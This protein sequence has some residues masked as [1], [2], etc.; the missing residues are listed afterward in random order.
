MALIPPTEASSPFQ[1]RLS[2]NILLCPANIIVPFR[3]A[4]PC[5]K[6]D[7]S[8]S[9][10]PPPCLFSKAKVLL[11]CIPPGGD[12]SQ[13]LTLCHPCLLQGSRMDEQR[14]SFPPPL[15]VCP[16]FPPL[17]RYTRWALGRRGQPQATRPFLSAAP[18]LLGN[19]A[20]Q[21][22]MGG[23]FCSGYPL[24]GQLSFPLGF[25]GLQP[26]LLPSSARLAETPLCPS[27]AQLWEVPPARKCSNVCK[28]LCGAVT[29]CPREICLASDISK[30]W[31]WG[32]IA[33]RVRA[34]AQ[35]PGLVPP[36]AT[37]SG[38]AA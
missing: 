16:S 32:C 34:T 11:A 9:S 25:Q 31:G 5:A 20:L 10:S 22:G 17:L 18:H 2:V 28:P 27:P 8:S 36:L 30:E 38:R 19:G 37:S 29:R 33:F 12:H 1:S 4:C 7:V 26:V 6:Q 24:I 14:C 3:L 13:V 35:G 15:K 21:P 23:R